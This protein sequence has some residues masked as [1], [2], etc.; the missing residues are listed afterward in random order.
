MNRV[1]HSPAASGPDRRRE[2][3]EDAV[4]WAGEFFFLKQRPVA[5][6]RPAAEELDGAVIGL[7]RAERDAAI[8]KAQAGSGAPHPRSADPENGG[9]GQPTGAPRRCRRPRSQPPTPP[10][11]CL[12]SSANAT[13]SSRSPVVRA[14]QRDGAG[15]SEDT[16]N[17]DVARPQPLTAKPFSPTAVRTRAGGRWAW[18]GPVVSARDDHVADR[19][20][21]GLTIP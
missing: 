20:R 15:P 14:S 2:P 19:S 10:T 5:V 6:E 11:S 3:R 7:E 8:T 13:A 16:L 21:V 12:R 18:S 4:A 17:S 9:S 1:P